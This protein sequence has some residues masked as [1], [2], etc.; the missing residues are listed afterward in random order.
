MDRSSWRSRVS[1]SFPVFDRCQLKNQ[2]R[3]ISSLIRSIDLSP[4]I[5]IFNPIPY[6]IRTRHLSRD[7]LILIDLVRRSWKWSR[8][9]YMGS[10]TYICKQW[11]ER[12]EYERG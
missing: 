7:R 1:Y 2:R 9:Q 5:I 6:T 8:S 3:D 10:G 4:L 12:G 11:G